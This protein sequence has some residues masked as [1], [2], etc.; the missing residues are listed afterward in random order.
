MKCIDCVYWLNCNEASRDKI[1]CLKYEKRKSD[2]RLK[3]K[4][5]D[6]FEFEKVYERES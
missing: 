4:D 5:G 2:T 1:D 3:E 6:Y